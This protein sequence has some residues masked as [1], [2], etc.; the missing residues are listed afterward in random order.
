MGHQLIANIKMINLQKA[1]VVKVLENHK[2]KIDRLL[3]EKSVEV[4][5]LQEA[6]R[7]AK[8]ALAEA[9]EE[10]ALE[11]KRREKTEAKVIEKEKQILEAKDKSI[12]D[13][14]VSKEMEDIKIDFTK[15]AF[16]QGFELCLEKVAKKFPKLNLSFLGGK[17]SDDEADPFAAATQ[18]SPT[19]SPA[20]TFEPT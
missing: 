20:A 19:K 9:K 13:F 17:S 15:I 2:V 14:K 8:Q 16:I 7:S 10:L 1:K 18:L 4:G 5:R 3:K 12:V 11:V 6:V